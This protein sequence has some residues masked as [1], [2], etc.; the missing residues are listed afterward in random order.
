RSECE[1]GG[2]I[3]I[4]GGTVN[5]TN[6]TLNGNSATFGGGLLNGFG[7]CPPRTHT[8]GAANL[9]DVTLSGN[10]GTPGYQLAN[11]FGTITLKNT[12]LGVSASL[13]CA[14]TVAAKSLG[15]NL[16]TD[17]SC[18]LTT[19]GDQQGVDP[20]LGPLADN[21]GP[22]LTQRLLLGSLAIDTGTDA[23]CPPTDQRGVPRPQGQA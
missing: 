19:T 16:S 12:I 18:G 22:T 9:T 21:G 23:G 14:P 1:G 10:S 20:L 5:L 7:D 8:G 6:V 11:A 2:G 15:S 3:R 13:N 4:A 17:T